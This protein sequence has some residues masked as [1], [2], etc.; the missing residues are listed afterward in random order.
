MDAS[1][2][3]HFGFQSISK[4]MSC[5]EDEDVMTRECPC[6][7]KSN[8]YSNSKQNNW[9]YVNQQEKKQDIVEGFHKAQQHNPWFKSALPIIPNSQHWFL[10]NVSKRKQ[11]THLKGLTKH[12][13]I[14]H[15]REHHQTILDSQQL[16]LCK[17]A[18][19]SKTYI[20]RL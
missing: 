2:T 20:R 8:N 11:D 6:H 16:V 7:S 4:S 1:S 10:W 19:G 18:K 17:L 13:N 5:K 15:R 14:M 12:K 3:S 9:F